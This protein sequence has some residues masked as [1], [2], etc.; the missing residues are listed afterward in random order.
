[1]EPGE[2][3]IISTLGWMA[4]IA[5]AIFVGALANSEKVYAEEIYAEM[6]LLYSYIDTLP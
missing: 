1:V 5:T 6:S 3:R 4:T 2:V